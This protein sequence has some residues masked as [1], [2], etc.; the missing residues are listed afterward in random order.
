MNVPILLLDCSKEIEEKLKKLNFNVQSGTIGY[1][2]GKKNLPSQVYEN[3]IFIYNPSKVIKITP[4][5]HQIGWSSYRGPVN[6]VSRY[7]KKYD[8]IDETP[9]FPLLPLVNRLSMGASMLV[10]VNDICEDIDVLNEVY[11]WIPSMPKIFRTK[12]KIIFRNQDLDG[13]NIGFLKPIIFEEQVKIPV[14]N[15]LEASTNGIFLFGNLNGERL[16]E[17]FKFNNGHLILLPQYK[18][19][20]ETILIFLNRVISKIYKQKI[21]T[22]ISD[23]FISKNE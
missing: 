9:E 8:I 19:N 12:D 16:G 4:K 11:S 14:V 20:D 3:T 15:K 6:R 10:F 18:S 13:K 5:P 7:I 1:C 23:E 17:Y 22:K 2:N 21:N